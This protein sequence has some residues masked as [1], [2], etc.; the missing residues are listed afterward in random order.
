MLNSV[1]KFCVMPKKTLL[2]TKKS[3]RILNRAIVKGFAQEL[4]S[5]A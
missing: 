3:K 2:L 4:Y 1:G 5:V